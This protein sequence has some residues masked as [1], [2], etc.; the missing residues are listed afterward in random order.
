[1]ILF[2]KKLDRDGDGHG[3]EQNN[4]PVVAEEQRISEEHRKAK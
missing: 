3:Q 2:F 4:S 1:L